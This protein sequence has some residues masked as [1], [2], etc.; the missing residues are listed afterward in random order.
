MPVFEQI[1][2][3]N[4]VLL[5]AECQAHEGL[6]IE[7]PDSARRGI[8]ETAVCGCGRTGPRLKPNEQTEEIRTIA[9]YAR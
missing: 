9:A 5:A 8:F 2:G 7:S 1:I 6:H 4:G 3:K